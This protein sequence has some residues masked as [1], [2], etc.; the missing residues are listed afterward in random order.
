ME[1]NCLA[2]IQKNIRVEGAMLL[3]GCPVHLER[4]PTLHSASFHSQF[5]T[6]TG[7]AAGM[8]ARSAVLE[9]VLKS[10]WR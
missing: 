2:A 10:G 3:E 6:S 9:I 5:V 4:A 8:R 1:I 7:G